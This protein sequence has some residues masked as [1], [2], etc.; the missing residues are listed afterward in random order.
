MALRNRRSGWT[1][2]HV[3][4]GNGLFTVLLHTGAFGGLGGIGGLSRRCPL[5]ARVARVTDWENNPPNQPSDS[6]LLKTRK[7]P[8]WVNEILTHQQPTT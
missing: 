4:F 3:D 8:W 2:T 6:K 7:L 5:R 1:R